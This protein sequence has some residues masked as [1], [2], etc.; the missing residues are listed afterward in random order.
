MASRTK[1]DPQAGS[2]FATGWRRFVGRASWG[3]PAG[4]AALA[5][6]TVLDLIFGGETVLT[7]SYVVAPFIAAFSGSRRSTVAVGA[8]AIALAAASGAWNGG[9]GGL[10]YDLRLGL[11]VLAS[12]LAYLA[13]AARSKSKT[14]MRRFQ[15][16]DEV[17]GVADGSLPLGETLERVTDVIVP[18]LADFCMIDVNSEGEPTRAAVRAGGPNPARVEAWLWDRKPTIPDYLLR[19]DEMPIAEPW[20]VPKHNQEF[21][22]RFSQGP[23]DLEFLRSLRTRSSIAVGFGARGKRM[24]VLTLVTAWSRRRYRGDDVRFARVLAGRVG[25]VLDNAGLFSDLQSVERRMDT[26]MSIL[27]EAVVIQDRRG[28]LLYANDAAEKMFGSTPE[29]LATATLDEMRT[30][31]EIYDEQGSRL[32]PSEFV[33]LRVLR[34]EAGNDQTVNVIERES[35]RELWLRARSRAIEGTDGQPLYAVTTF[36]DVT[37]G[38]Q[39]EFAQA[40]LARTGEL[41]ASSIDYRE[42][43]QRVAHLTIPQL[44]DWCFVCAQEEEGEFELL[45]VAHSDPEKLGLARQIVAEYPLEMGDPSEVAEALRSAEPRLVED[46]ESAIRALARDERHLE[47]LRE[48]GIGSAMMF[49]MQVGDEVVGA[50]VFANGIDRHPFEEFDR[51]LAS[52]IA[53]RAAIAIENSR[54]ATE[55]SA[56]AETLQRGLAPPQIPDVP[57]W[58]AAAVYHPA[59][60]ENR[61]GGDFYDVF[62]YEGGWMVVIGDVTGRGA[63]AAAVTAL[64]R[65]T[66]RTAGRLTGNPI[67]ALEL[68]NESLLAREDNAL[69]TAAIVT[70]PGNG[71]DQ[72]QIAVA[73]HPLPLIIREGFVEEAGRLGPALGAF[74]GSRWEIDR[75]SLAPGDQLVVYTDGVIEASRQGDRFGEERLRRRIVGSTSPSGTIQQVEHA[76]EGFTAGHLTDDAAMVAVMREPE[77]LPTEP[78]SGVAGSGESESA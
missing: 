25:L 28:R 12:G 27:G 2:S 29:Q 13:A 69:C 47:R 36:D 57:G 74:A 15:I 70:L 77:A 52:Q 51:S 40:M 49:P 22:R 10:D 16:L 18:E 7:G 1:G 32:D 75:S 4:L 62:P 42:T 59:G 17:A 24:G 35:G 60:S 50:L 48:F 41:L 72:V 53:E 9:Y 38:K 58:S 6:V 54:L 45:A 26:A 65:Y 39:A 76:L 5:V 20:F 33:A 30:R 78:L 71:A 14:A 21:L 64:A 67:S 37:A 63:E 66:I 31:Y 8:L 56:I 44:A 61:V 55:R 43:L 46:A 3:F 68:L 11:L 73:G 23:E 34:G 19:D